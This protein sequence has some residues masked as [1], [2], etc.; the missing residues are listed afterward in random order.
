[1]KWLVVLPA[2]PTMNFEIQNENKICIESKSCITDCV[3]ISK[4][5][6]KEIYLSF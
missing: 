5:V 6:S 1:M 4:I 2:L 3:T